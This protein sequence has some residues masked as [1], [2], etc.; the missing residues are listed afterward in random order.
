MVFK[1]LSFSAVIILFI[2]QLFVTPVL[3]QTADKVT[4]NVLR[5]NAINPG[6][7]IEMA[8]FSKSTI[9]IH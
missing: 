3:G 4:Q 8:V 5:I 6:V 9:S 2:A 7:E 1:K